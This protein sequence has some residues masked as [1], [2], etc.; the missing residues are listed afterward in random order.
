MTNLEI[1]KEIKVDV[2]YN[3]WEVWA[4]LKR[5]AENVHSSVESLSTYRQRN[6]IDELVLFD[7]EAPLYEILD[8]LKD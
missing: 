5:I 7:I 2:T 1:N 3:G 8:L 4:L 6:D